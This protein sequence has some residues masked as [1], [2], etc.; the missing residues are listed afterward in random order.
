MSL[1]VAVCNHVS[2]HDAEFKAGC[3]QSLY[4]EIFGTARV[5]PTES[6]SCIVGAQFLVMFRVV[7]VLDTMI[8]GAHHDYF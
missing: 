4:I 2:I 7:G 5:Q 8:H 3:G 6:C 1:G